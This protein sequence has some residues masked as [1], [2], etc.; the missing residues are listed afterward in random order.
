MQAGEYIDRL[1]KQDRREVN[2]LATGSYV[3]IKISMQIELWASRQLKQKRKN[4]VHIIHK[5][6]TCYISR[7]ANP[8]LALRN[9]RIFSCKY[10]ILR[11]LNDAVYKF[12]KNIPAKGQRWRCIA[13]SYRYSQWVWRA[14]TNRAFYNFPH[15]CCFLAIGVL[16]CG[17]WKMNI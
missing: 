13:I 1:K 7:E 3:V 15:L 17:F 10:L 9:E 14:K 2:I 4:V 6:K 12:L 16:M 11:I 5:E 8:F